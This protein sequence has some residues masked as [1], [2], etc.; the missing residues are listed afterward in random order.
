MLRKSEAC[1]DDEGLSYLIV[2][3]DQKTTQKIK[4][5][6]VCV[7][8]YLKKKER[9]LLVREQTIFLMIFYGDFLVYFFLPPFYFS[10]H[11]NFNLELMMICVLATLHYR[12]IELKIFIILL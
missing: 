3:L 12:Y 8:I 10:Q 9:V 11:V 5:V 7:I 4:C 2:L 1:I 6:C